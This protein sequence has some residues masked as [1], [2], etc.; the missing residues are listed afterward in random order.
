MKTDRLIDLIAELQSE[1]ISIEKLAAN[2]METWETLPAETREKKIHESAIALNLH[3][4]YTGVEKVFERIADDLNGGVPGGRERHKRLLHSM[5]LELPDLRP[6][7]ISGAT[8]IAM[9]EF[10]AFRHIVRNIYAFEID[11]ER[12]ALLMKR[13]PNAL[14]CFK[15]DVE[16]FID[17]LQRQKNKCRTS[18]IVPGDKFEKRIV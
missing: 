17:F 15:R 8:E 13:F 1:I 4:F 9:Y 10:L 7:V 16:S 3:N 2:L 18:G 6:P 11:S 5:T 14:M 12:L